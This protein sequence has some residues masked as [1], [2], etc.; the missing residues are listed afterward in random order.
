[1]LGFVPFWF[2]SRRGDNG[3]LTDGS[4]PDLGGADSL[5]EVGRASASRSGARKRRQLLRVEASEASPLQLTA[6]ERARAANL[7]EEVAA[8]LTN[9]Q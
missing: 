6:E 5:P 7:F 8:Q 1:M 9:A 3:N 4:S 2:A